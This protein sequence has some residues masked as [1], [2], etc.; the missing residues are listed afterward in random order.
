MINL[1]KNESKN[2]IK[3]GSLLE[4]T[5]MGIYFV[6]VTVDATCLV[7]IKWLS[8]NHR[9]KVSS[10]QRKSLVGTIPVRHSH[11][12]RQNHLWSQIASAVQEPVKETAIGIH[13]IALKS[14]FQLQEKKKL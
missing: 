12:S 9:Q 11:V 1:F 7:D 14:T 5:K 6:V 3:Y 10:A 8:T 13:K 2:L 4:I